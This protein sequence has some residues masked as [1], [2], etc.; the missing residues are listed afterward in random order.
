MSAPIAPKF[1]CEHCSVLFTK[2]YNL[3]RHMARQHTISDKNSTT[4]N[5]HDSTQN[6]HDVTQNSH[7]NSCPFCYKVFTRNWCLIRHVEIC[8]GENNK[9]QCIY[10]QKEFKHNKSRFQHYKICKVKKEIDSKALI[11]IEDEDTPATIAI[12]GTV[13]TYQEANNIN[14]INTLETQNNIQNQQNNIIIVYNPGNT[15]FKTDHLKAEDLQKILQLASP[16]VDNQAMREYTK[17]IFSNPE[18]QCIKKE[19]LKSGHSEI[20]LGDNQW[21]LELD[22]NIYPKLASNMANNMAEFLHTKRDQMRREVFDRLTKF[23]DYMADEGYINTDDIDK[24]KVIQKEYKTFTKGLKL[25]V[26]G[27]KKTK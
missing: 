1:N 23:V 6:S 3:L 4:Q 24:Q 18:N 14:N 5:S 9:H 10:C 19:D 8:K 27:K 20:H 17:K 13:N 26:F 22:T 15:D 12:P 21:E 2:K 16:Y 25:I 7:D 11:T